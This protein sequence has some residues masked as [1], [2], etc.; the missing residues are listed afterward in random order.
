[1]FLVLLLSAA[2]QLGTPW[3]VFDEGGIADL[4]D[5]A[6]QFCQ[7]CKMLQDGQYNA[8]KI[9]LGSPEKLCQTSNRET[10]RISEVAEL[11]KH[12]V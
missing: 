4:T 7:H 12:N 2:N 9:G 1:M 5:S 6:L 3:P 11:F 10:Y 8:R